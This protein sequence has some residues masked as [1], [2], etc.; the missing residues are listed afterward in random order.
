MIGLGTLYLIPTPLAKTGN[1]ETIS[2]YNRSVIEGL[3]HFVCERIPTAISFLEFIGMSK[4]I[5]ELTFLELNKKSSSEQLNEC[6]QPLL[7]GESVGVLSEAGA[8]AIADPGSD[9]VAQAHLYQI[10]VVPLTGPTSF[11]LALMASGL[12]GQRFRFHGYL[13]RKYDHLRGQVTEMEQDSAM[14]RES[15]IFME[16]PQRNETIFRHLKDLLKSDTM[17]S[18]SCNLT[19]ADGWTKTA[20]IGEWNAQ[21]MPDFDKQPCVFIIQATESAAGKPPPKNATVTRVKR[22]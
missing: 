10:E 15:Q 9:L 11:A 7:M 1:P 17:L 18:I 19:H 8:P 2:V 5:P 22:W 13:S 14:R 12:D 21:T 4:R 20:S 16:A 6:L 3:S